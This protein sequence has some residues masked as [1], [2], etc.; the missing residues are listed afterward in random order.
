MS[1]PENACINCGIVVTGPFCSQCGQSQ[2]DHS[3]PLGQVIAEILSSFFHFDGRIQRTLGLL[4]VR[5]GEPPRLWIS[6]KRADLVPPVRLYMFVS[7]LF[8]LVLS[9]TDMALIALVPVDAQ[10][11]VITGAI[12]FDHDESI[13]DNDK[14]ANSA[15]LSVRA[16]VPMSEVSAGEAALFSKLRENVKANVKLDASPGEDRNLGLQRRLIESWDVYLSNPRALNRAIGNAIPKLMFCFL[17]LAAVIFWLVTPGKWHFVDH[18]AVSFYLHSFFF[19]ALFVLML[20]KV[21]ILQYAPATS[22]EPVGQ[23]LMIAFPLYVALTMQR[24]Y[25]LS[26]LGTIVRSALALS[27]Y[28]ANFILF[29]IPLMLAILSL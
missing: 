6:G 20:G 28:G 24:A 25:R 22:L 14:A 3:K 17:P 21:W 19:I 27:F 29:S 12:N 26:F 1:R 18:L 4:L 16:L 8:F 23:G 13:S 11:S 15:T 7:L 5:P 2:G 10:G 9:G